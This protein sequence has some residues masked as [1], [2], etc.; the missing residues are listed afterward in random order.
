MKQIQILESADTSCK[1]NFNAILISPDYIHTPMISN[2]PKTDVRQQLSTLNLQNIKHTYSVSRWFEYSS[3]FSS[4][5]Q[6]R[7]I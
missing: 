3:C 7:I 4:T 2:C 1:K 5:V 6:V